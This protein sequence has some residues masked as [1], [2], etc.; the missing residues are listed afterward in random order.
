[1]NG[2]GQECILVHAKIPANCTEKMF[3][4][5]CSFFV[6]CGFDFCV[7]QHKLFLSSQS[8]TLILCVAKLN[9]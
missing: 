5:R 3:G 6:C 8:L 7:G 2:N 9:K 1:M 4:F